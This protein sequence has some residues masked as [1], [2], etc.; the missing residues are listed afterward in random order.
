MKK[1]VLQKKDVKKKKPMFTRL[2]RGLICTIQIFK[3][4]TGIKFPQFREL[5]IY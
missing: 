5:A 4:F 1:D 3:I 2:A